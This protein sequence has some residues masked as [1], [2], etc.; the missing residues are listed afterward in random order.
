MRHKSYALLLSRNYFSG[1]DAG[2]TPERTS[3]FL[4]KLR[5]P[6]TRLIWTRH[7]AGDREIGFADDIS[8]FDFVLLA[9]RKIEQRLLERQL[10]RRGDY[11]T[12]VYA[13]FDWMNPRAGERLFDNDRPTVLYTPHFRPA[14]SSWTKWGMA[15]LDLFANS[16]RYK[17]IFA[18][19][20]RLFDPPAAECYA[21]FE[22][23]RSEERR[24]GKEC[25][26]TCRSRWSLVH[27]K[28]KRRIVV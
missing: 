3:L 2:V 27:V 8:R 16:N 19:H 23:Y 25:V 6:N 18:P 14:L 15:V 17:L 28:K 22:R 26:S 7:G 21:Q 13:K 4:K 1:F 24:V 9:R 5:L 10:I 12:G 20:V 11:A